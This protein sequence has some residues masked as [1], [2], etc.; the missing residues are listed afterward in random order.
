M[1]S[2]MSF[3]AFAFDKNR[4]FD[5]KNHIIGKITAINTTNSNTEITLNIAEANKTD[6]NNFRLRN[7]RFA[8]PPEAFRKNDDK[9]PDKNKKQDKDNKKSIDNKPDKDSKANDNNKNFDKEKPKFEFKTEDMFKLTDKTVNYTYSKKVDNLKVGDYVFIELEDENSKVIKN[10]R[11]AQ[12]DRD[13][14]KRNFNV[15]NK[16]DDKKTK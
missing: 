11:P 6:E 16:K 12:F 15:D 7:G 10:I 14:A 9:L 5:N 13:F 3:N 8:T 1:L 4:E 2:S